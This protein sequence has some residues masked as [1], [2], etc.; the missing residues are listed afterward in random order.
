MSSMGRHATGQTSTHSWQPRRIAYANSGMT[1]WSL[2]RACATSSMSMQ[3]PRFGR[4]I[5]ALDEEAGGNSGREGV[6]RDLVRP[7]YS[8]LRAG[9]L[10]DG[11]DNLTGAW[12][13]RPHA[14]ARDALEG[15]EFDLQ[16]GG[17]GEAA[18][19]LAPIE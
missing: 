1:I 14:R 10:P 8:E 19:E 15:R 5:V 17:G 2:A 7:G 9:D 16:K 18:D 4:S 11:A 13:K 6:L 12:H 3:P